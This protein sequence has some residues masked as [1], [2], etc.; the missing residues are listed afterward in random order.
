MLNTVIFQI[1]PCN[2]LIHKTCFDEMVSNGH[3][4]CPLCGVSM[5]NMTDVW[6]IYDK[7]ISETP[8]PEEYQDL[9]ANIQCRDCLKTSL[10]IFHILGLKCGECGGYNTVRDK[11]PLVRKSPEVASM[12]PPLSPVTQS[13]SQSAGPPV[14]QVFDP[15][16]EESSVT[17]T[18]E[19]SPVRL[20]LDPELDRGVSI[21]LV[22]RRLDF[23]DQME[24]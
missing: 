9:Y 11:G 21:S 7:E 4:A 16:A 22:A 6:K 10:T 13:A 24:Q 18:P 20:E 12:T 23:D 15:P 2:H 1:P 3:Y 17:M 8:M 19:P 14:S 5:M